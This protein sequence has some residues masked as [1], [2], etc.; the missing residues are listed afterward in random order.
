MRE[1]PAGAMEVKAIGKMWVWSFE[2]SGGRVSPEL[3]VPLNKPIKLNLVSLDVIHSLYIP[4][5]R[6]KEDMVP[7]TA[8]FMWFIPQELGEFDILCAEYC[9]MKHS[10]MES[11]VRV[12]TQEDYDKWLAALPEQKVEP[13]GLV[14]LKKNACLGCH[15]IDGKKGVSTTFKG[16]YGKSHT[17]I[18]NGTEREAIADDLYLK[19]SIFNP[20]LDVV[21]GFPDGVMKSYKGVVTKEESKKIIE[22]IKSIKE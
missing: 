10:F 6:I 13:E 5:F 8:D 12:L 2:Y 7:G 1:A 16:L 4:A 19:N 9:G 15:S 18:T 14:I 22:Y 3:V 21:K 20:S 11:K 17:V